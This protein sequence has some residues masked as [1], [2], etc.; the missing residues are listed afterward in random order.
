MVAPKKGSLE[1]LAAV[2]AALGGARTP[3]GQALVQA[4]IFVGIALAVI[5]ASERGGPATKTFVG[6]LLVPGFFI[7]FV[8]FIRV[9]AA[10]ARE[11]REDM[12]SAGP[13][14]GKPEEPEGPK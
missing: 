3:V 10:V 5:W 8:L 14:S 6:F 9:L 11:V 12:A 13:K 1:G 4:G 7:G 2:L